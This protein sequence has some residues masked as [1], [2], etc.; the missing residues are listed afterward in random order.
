L[1][2]VLDKNAGKKQVQLR[3]LA[4]K[5]RP[6]TETS[7]LLRLCWHRWPAAKVL[8]RKVC[9]ETNRTKGGHQCPNMPIV[10]AA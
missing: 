9:E 3:G 7:A 4:I 5:T 1:E 6:Y 2:A 8:R 10:G